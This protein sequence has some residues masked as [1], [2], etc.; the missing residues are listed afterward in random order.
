M[1]KNENYS[2]FS[3]G[4]SYGSDVAHCGCEELKVRFDRFDEGGDEEGNG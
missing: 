4:F 1:T 3:Y 2:D